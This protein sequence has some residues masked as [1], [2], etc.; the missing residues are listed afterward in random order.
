MGGGAATYVFVLCQIGIGARTRGLTFFERL[1]E[2]W[3][4]FAWPWYMGTLVI[5]VVVDAMI[6]SLYAKMLQAFFYPDLATWILRLV[7]IGVAAWLARQ[8]L[9]VLARNVQV[10]FPISLL[11]LAILMLL[12]FPNARMPGGIRPVWPPEPQSVLQGVLQT[13]FLWSFPDAAV[14]MV[15]GLRRGTWPRVARLAGLSFAVQG[16][17]LLALAVLLLGT[18][19]PWPSETLM[20]PGIYLFVGLGPTS[21]SFLRPSMLILPMWT[22]SFVLFQAVRLFAQGANLQGALR[23][24]AQGR[25]VYTAILAATVFACT[26]FLPDAPRTLDMLSRD[27][28]PV[29]MVWAALQFGG[30]WLLAVV[31]GLKPVTEVVPP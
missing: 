24:P 25:H 12:A 20:W 22:A 27:V 18:L 1:R 2:V 26:L 3:G 8:T 17:V 23:A 29:A 7:L 6:L 5:T 16:L 28:S 4:P 11:S 21:T 15:V 9:A 31:R 30:T 19:G 13:G 14:T 10:W